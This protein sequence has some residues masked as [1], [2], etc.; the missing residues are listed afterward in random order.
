MCRGSLFWI[1]KMVR[2][3]ALPHPRD[4]SLYQPAEDPGCITKTPSIHHQAVAS[5]PPG[6]TSSLAGGEG[7]QESNTNLYVTGHGAHLDRRGTR[8]RAMITRSKEPLLGSGEV[9]GR[10]AGGRKGCC[11]MR[12]RRAGQVWQ[13]PHVW[14]SSLPQDDFIEA[15]MNKCD[16]V[17]HVVVWLSMPGCGQARRARVGHGSS[18]NAPA[19]L[20]GR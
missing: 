2:T 18:V 3:T 20:V 6:G 10:L 4:A 16:N 8:S 15:G 7:G 11:V 13:P 1:W 9:A 19:W 12:Q 17:C 14:R 5:L